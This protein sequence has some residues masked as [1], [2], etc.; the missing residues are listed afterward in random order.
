MGAQMK[1]ARDLY[2]VNEVW[3]AFCDM[4]TLVTLI[5][6]LIGGVLAVLVILHYLGQ[7]NPL[8]CLAAVA[9]YALIAAI[10]VVVAFNRG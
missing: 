7:T 1:I 3:T 9:V 4:L 2:R 8:F 6:I 10:S 5:G